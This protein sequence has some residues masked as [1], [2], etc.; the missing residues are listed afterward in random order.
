[1][2][3]LQEPIH[4]RLNGNIEKPVGLSHKLFLQRYIL[5]C[6]FNNLHLGRRQ[7]GRTFLPASGYQH[8]EYR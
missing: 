6:H 8:K 1:M 3:P 2:D 4:T 5:L 7:G